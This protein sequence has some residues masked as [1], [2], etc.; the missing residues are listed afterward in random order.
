MAGKLKISAS[1]DAADISYKNDN[2]DVTVKPNNKEQAKV[3]IDSMRDSDM[4]KKLAAAKKD[5]SVRA[6]STRSINEK[7]FEEAGTKSP[8][9]HM[10]LSFDDIALRR[11]TV[12]KHEDVAGDNKGSDVT[13]RGRITHSTDEPDNNHVLSALNEI[14]SLMTLSMKPPNLKAFDQVLPL[15][16]EE[17]KYLNTPDV[18]KKLN[19]AAHKKRRT[20]ASSPE[21]HSRKSAKHIVNNTPHNSSY[22]EDPVSPDYNTGYSGKSQFVHLPRHHAPAR[23]QTARKHVAAASTAHR[24]TRKKCVRGHCRQEIF[25]GPDI[26]P[27]P[28]A[29]DGAFEELYLGKIKEHHD[30]T[31]RLPVEFRG[32]DPDYDTLDELED[33]EHAGVHGG[34]CG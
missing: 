15:D 33:R 34:L 21:S 22:S 23:K 30:G 11:S 2:V 13:W 27:N 26:G 17:N 20:P 32:R 19:H 7:S 9:V 12:G 8:K 16:H 6:P 10:D 18:M 29:P 4:G 24:H 25:G 5:E 14:K 3:V 31:D 28:E 1:R